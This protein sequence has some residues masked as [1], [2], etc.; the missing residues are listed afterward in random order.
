MVMNIRQIRGKRL[1]LQ[2]LLEIFNALHIVLMQVMGQSSSVVDLWVILF[3]LFCCCEVF[4]GFLFKILKKERCCFYFIVNRLKN[5][6]INIY[7]RTLNQELG[8]FW[9]DFQCFL[10]I[11]QGLFCVFCE[12][13]C[14]CKTA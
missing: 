2:R 14:L 6:N 4:D 8:I 3:V 1:V 9:S 10:Q 13:E 7:L 5:T 12:T 11:V